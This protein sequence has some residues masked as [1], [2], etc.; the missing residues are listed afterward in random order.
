[1]T[2]G[3]ARTASRFGPSARIRAEV[4]DRSDAAIHG[5]VDAGD[6]AALVRGEEQRRRGDFLGTPEAPGL[7]TLARIL[8][9]FSSVVQVLTKERSAALVAEYVLYAGNPFT[10]TPEPFR[11]IEPPSLSR[12]KA[13][14]TVK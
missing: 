4:L 12:G 6:V 8:R 3:M 7:I 9:S 10:H 13:F 2:Y 5:Q 14:C 11:M 1:M